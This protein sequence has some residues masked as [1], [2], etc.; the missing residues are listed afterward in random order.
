MESKKFTMDFAGRLVDAGICKYAQQAAGSVLV[1]YGDTVI[2]VNVTASDK[3][4]TELT[5]SH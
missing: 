2:M 4:R 3:P 5:F 1:H